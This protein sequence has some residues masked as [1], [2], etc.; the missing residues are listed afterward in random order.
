MTDPELSIAELEDK[1]DTVYVFGVASEQPPSVHKWMNDDE[2]FGALWDNTFD[3]AEVLVVPGMTG[4]TEVQ[5]T[6]RDQL[7]AMLESVDRDTDA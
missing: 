5:Q 6:T 7:E 1:P 2:G 3:H 4:I